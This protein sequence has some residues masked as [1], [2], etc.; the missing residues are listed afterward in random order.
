MFHAL[1]NESSFLKDI[2]LIRVFIELSPGFGHQSAAINVIKKINELG[3]RGQFEVIYPHEIGDKIDKLFSDGVVSRRRLKIKTRVKYLYELENGQIKPVFLAISAADDRLVQEM[4]NLAQSEYFIQLQPQGWDESYIYTHNNK[5][6][7][8]G[9]LM[10][11]LANVQNLSKKKFETAV[12]KS[13]VINWNV[14]QLVK[15][16]S[17]SIELNDSANEIEFFPIYGVGLLNSAAIK[18]RTYLKTVAHRMKIEKNQKPILVPIISRFQELEMIEFDRQFGKRSGFTSIIPDERRFDNRVHIIDLTHGDQLPDFQSGN[19]YLIFTG[20]IPHYIFEFLIAHST[21]PVWVAGKN[22]MNLAL[23]HGKPY[24]NTVGDY[25]LPEIEIQSG[26]VKRQ[27]QNI[28]Y[29]FN[30]LNRTR[31]HQSTLLEMSRFVADS[32]N[33]E[34]LLMQYF[35]RMSGQMRRTDKVETAFEKLQLI[36]QG[37]ICEKVFY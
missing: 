14:K 31:I 24:L 7:L 1:A 12:D 5:F 8:K 37:L 29:N 21:M 15:L 17:Q 23:K 26:K 34:S 27:L 3:Y 6:H 16:I 35:N 4:K 33:S 18:I 30:E 32:R 13:N 20:F 25:Y 36:H 10:L 9:S 28:S 22:A 19:I 2:Q 11:S